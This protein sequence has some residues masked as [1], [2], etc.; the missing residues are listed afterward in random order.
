MS[1][2]AKPIQLE[3]RPVGLGS[4]PSD[5]ILDL[6][7]PEPKEGFFFSYAMSKVSG[8]PHPCA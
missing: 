5:P 7:G 8:F 3:S 2:A 4:N 6:G 1:L